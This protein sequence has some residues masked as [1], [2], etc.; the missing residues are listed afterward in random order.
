MGS[1][2]Q[3]V[4]SLAYQLFSKNGLK[5][6]QKDNFPVTKLVCTS[7]FQNVMQNNNPK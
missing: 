6:F 5:L 7:S 3:M 2:R 1:D 4:H